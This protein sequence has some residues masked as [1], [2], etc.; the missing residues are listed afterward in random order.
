MIV[1]SQ[2]PTD[3]RNNAFLGERLQLIR[4]FCGYTQKEMATLLGT[5]NVAISEYENGRRQP[6]AKIVARAAF[7]T[8]FFPSFFSDQIGKPFSE[9]ECSFR[10]RRT[11]SQK[12]KN[13]VRAQASLLGII[14]TALREI[15]R[16]PNLS[17]PSIRASTDDDVEKAAMQCR[18]FWQLD[19]KAPLKQIGR[20]LERAGVIIIASSVETNK[21]DAFSHLGTNPIVFLN[22]GAGTSP[23]RWNFD[24]AHELGHLV[25]H[26]G[27]I[28]G[29]IE[30]EA[31]ADKF[32][33]AFLL[34]RDGFAAEFG[35][36]PFSWS[37][38]FELKQRWMVSAAAIVRRGRDL[39]LINEA[40]Y[41]RSFQYMSAKRWRQL[42][43]PYEPVFQ[44]PELFTDSIKSLRSNGGEDLDNLCK[45]LGFTTAV[46][47][48]ITGEQTQLSSSSRLLAFPE[49]CQVNE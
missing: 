21:I 1:T 4:E 6:P 43:E 41:R 8:G 39:G 28:T 9:T 2:L 23:S 13:Q 29:S 47:T 17:L 10:H 30:S 27:Q 15:F 19:Q 49:V 48:R 44:E 7:E 3:N 46:F 45:S 11:T 31:A 32:A 42:G 20:A 26:Q 14:V 33:S 34:P 18:S 16:F 22:R 35:Y 25:L 36:K 12:L 5:S 40:I 24:L 38:V 37:F